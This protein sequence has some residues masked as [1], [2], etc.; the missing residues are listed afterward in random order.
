MAAGGFY[1]D[2]SDLD[3]FALRMKGMRGAFK[4]MRSVHERVARRAAVDVKM[5]APLGK[6]SAKDSRSHMPP[7]YLKRSIR[8]RATRSN[9]YVSAGAPHMG[10]LFL[11]EFGGSAY[12]HTGGR[13][14]LRATNTGHAAVKQ[15]GKAVLVGLYSEHGHIVYQKSR[16]PRGYFIWNVAFRLRSTIAVMYCKGL[17]EVGA[18]HGISVTAAASPSLTYYGK[19]MGRTT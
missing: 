1:I 14:S 13:G 4:D 6:R 2:S 8:G 7:G 9:A 17:A 11:Q 3:R 10:Y 5:R 18:K 19:P 15:F 12:W 16:K